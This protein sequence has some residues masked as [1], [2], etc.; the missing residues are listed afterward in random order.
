[1]HLMTFIHIFEPS[2]LD[3]LLIRLAQG[4]FFNF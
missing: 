3:R 4:V 2:R 1:M